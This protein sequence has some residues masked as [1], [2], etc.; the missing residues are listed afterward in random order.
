MNR[1]LAIA[2]RLFV[3]RLCEHTRHELTSRE[4][5][6]CVIRTHVHLPVHE[7]EIPSVSLQF[8]TFSSNK[9]LGDARL[10]RSVFFGGN[11]LRNGHRVEQKHLGDRCR[12]C[13][14]SVQSI[15]SNHQFDASTQSRRRSLA[16][17]SCE[18][19]SQFPKF[20]HNSETGGNGGVF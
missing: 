19:N 5:T 1:L 2:N 10:E 17:R 13:K 3:S 8:N 14:A 15:S 18:C 9:K 12:V 7:R 6:P 11:I 20:F 4:L 16:G